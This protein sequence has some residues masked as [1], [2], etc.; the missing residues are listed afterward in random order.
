MV[1]RASSCLGVWGCPLYA[2]PVRF[3]E[4]VEDH[5]SYADTFLLTKGDRDNLI[6]R[7]ELDDRGVTAFSFLGSHRLLLPFGVSDGAGNLKISL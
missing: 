5:G 6:L 1:P 2:L 4:D 7:L 3:G